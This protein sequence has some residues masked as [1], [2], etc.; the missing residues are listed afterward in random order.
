MPAV[1]ANK[2]HNGTGLPAICN[3]IWAVGGDLESIEEAGDKARNVQKSL[4]RLGVKSQFRAA[5]SSY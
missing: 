2:I 3:V 1:E 5:L 4:M